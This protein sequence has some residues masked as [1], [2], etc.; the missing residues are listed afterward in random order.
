[1]NSSNNSLDMRDTNISSTRQSY[2][3]WPK[4]PHRGTPKDIQMSLRASESTMEAMKQL[5]GTSKLN[6]SLPSFCPAGPA[7]EEQTH[8]KDAS[9]QTDGLDTRIMEAYQ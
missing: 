2:S 5:W 6:P 7:K 4:L 3:N 9:Q 1:M 8:T